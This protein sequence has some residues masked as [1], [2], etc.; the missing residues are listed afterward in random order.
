M[1]TE[2]VFLVACIRACSLCGHTEN[3]YVPT[4][5][6]Y[7]ACACHGVCSY[8]VPPDASAHAR[9]MA[10]IKR[11]GPSHIEATRV[12]WLVTPM[13]PKKP[14]K[15]KSEPVPAGRLDKSAPRPK[16]VAPSRQL[17][18]WDGILDHMEAKSKQG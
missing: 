11:Q 9:L 14:K 18:F 4:A 1:H 2:R 3:P 12:G 10:T 13:H 5:C 15:P 17:N 8:E 6:V 16:R 7:E